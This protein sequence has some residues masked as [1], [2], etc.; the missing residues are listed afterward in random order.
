MNIIVCIRRA[1]VTDARIKPGADNKTYDPA[2][3][4]YDI[5]EYDKF[6]IEAGIVLKEKNPGSKV[7]V[8]TLGV[9]DSAKELRNAIAMGCDAATLLISDK[10]HDAF[11]TASTLAAK[12]KTMP[13]DIVFFGH[14]S[15]DNQC[16][17]TGQ[18][19]AEFLGLPCATVVTALNVEGG[20]AKIEREIEGGKRERLELKLPCALTCQKGLNKPRSASMKGI[21]AAKNTKV[22]EVPANAPANLLTV[23]KMDPPPPRPAGK[24]VGEG[25]DAAKKLVDLL[26]SEAKVI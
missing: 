5:S 23:T 11:A 3:V 13:H 9:K 21:M 12:I 25:P 14:V 6:A 18:M 7:T 10:E 8:V 20:V 22:E 26:H 24:I 19:T 16:S 4:N 17:G 2:G 15:V 1:P